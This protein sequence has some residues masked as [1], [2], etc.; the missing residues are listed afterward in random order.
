M[1]GP[2]KREKLSTLKRFKAKQRAN[3]ATTGK[4]HEVSLMKTIRE[5]EKIKSPLV[6]KVKQALTVARMFVS[7]IEG[8]MK[9]NAQTVK[10]LA[11]KVK[12]DKARKNREEKRKNKITKKIVSKRL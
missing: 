4:K 7:P 11:E 1:A 5:A 8:I 6:K 3:Y 10:N 12:E 9:I 2:T